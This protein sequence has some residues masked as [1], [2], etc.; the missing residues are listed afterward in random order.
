LT[1]STA[2]ALTTSVSAVT[3]NPGGSGTLTL[4]V[5]PGG[6][7]TGVVGLTCSSLVKYVTCAVANPSVTLSGTTASTS[8]ATITV[9]ATTSAVRGFG[10]GA[11]LAMLA[12]FGLLL[13]GS[14]KRLRGVVLAVMLLAAG[15]VVSGC[16][17]TPA[18]SGAASN[19]PVGTQLVSFT[20][21]A[22][23]VTQ[24]VQVVVT[25]P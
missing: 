7:F 5:L 1:V 9:A 16:G 3:V 15:M 22:A 10:G 6:G 4:S 19:V 24:T 20:A 2:F 8:G 14:R 13:L 25:I 17:G 21:T 11:V 18:A 12:P 23:G